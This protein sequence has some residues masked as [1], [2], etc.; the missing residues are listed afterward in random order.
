LEG[1][2]RRYGGL[3]KGRAEAVRAREI[4]MDRDDANSAAIVAMGPDSWSCCET[5]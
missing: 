5:A 1:V 2:W 3:D 4:V